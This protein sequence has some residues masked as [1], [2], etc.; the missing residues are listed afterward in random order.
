MKI[1]GFGSKFQE[2]KTG[3]VPS[4]KNLSSGE[5]KPS[6]TNARP[7][8]FRIQEAIQGMTIQKPSLSNKIDNK[9]VIKQEE[10]KICEPFDAVKVTLVLNK[11]IEFHRPE[12]A[13]E[14]ALKTHQPLIQEGKIMLL[15][16]NKLL[17]EKLE[18]IKIQL[19]S[20]LMKNLKHGALILDFQLFDTV[21]NQEEK[22]L[23]TSGE[24]FDHFVELN[25]IVAEL[26]KMFGLELE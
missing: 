15:V 25:P 7:D 26:K 11:Y 23:F 17:L 9:D 10:V 18:A 1:D 4:G 14:I 24:K 3:S 5:N 6:P 12:P 2:L 8:S 20:F 21:E 22:R 16:D 13:V 19:H